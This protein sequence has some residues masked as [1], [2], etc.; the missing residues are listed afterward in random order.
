MAVAL[1]RIRKELEELRRDPPE[2]CTAEP[3][4]DEDLFK[5]AGTIEGPPDTPYEGGVFQVNITFPAEYAVRAP[6]VIF[7]TKVYH[8]NVK[9]GTGEI[10]LDILK[11]NWSPALT[12]RTVLISLRSLLSDANPDHPLEADIASQYKTDKA[13]FDATAREWTDK[14]AKVE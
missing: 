5:W 12:V 8:P 13:A 10:C 2:G 14:Y 9:S 3:I 4:S 11:E 6:K 7:V 1:K